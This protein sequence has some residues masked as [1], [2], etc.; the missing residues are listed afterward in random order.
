M[1]MY[2]ENHLVLRGSLKQFRFLPHLQPPRGGTGNISGE[3]SYWRPRWLC[4]LEMAN[5][6][7]SGLEEGFLSESPGTSWNLSW[8]VRH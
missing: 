6:S 5:A 2:L 3:Q 8:L 7:G 1:C 4:W